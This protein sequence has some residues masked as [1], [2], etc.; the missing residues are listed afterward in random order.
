VF[1]IKTYLGN[2]LR[3][4]W[5]ETGER[6]LEDLLPDII[7]GILAAVPYLAER[8]RKQEEERENTRP[9]SAVAMS[10]NKSGSWNETDS[11]VSLNSPSNARTS[12]LPMSSLRLCE[13]RRRTILRRSATEQSKNGSIGSMAAFGRPTPSNKV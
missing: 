11:A 10:S 2:G 3:S 7:A 12:G 5:L 13:R 9:T 4:E 8:T 6:I 1:A